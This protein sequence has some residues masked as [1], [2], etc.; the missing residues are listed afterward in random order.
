MEVVCFCN[1]YADKNLYV[2]ELPRMLVY[3]GFLT[4]AGLI[5]VVREN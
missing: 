3:V 1:F 2:Y 5:R 4:L